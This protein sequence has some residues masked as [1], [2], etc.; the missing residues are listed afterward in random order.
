MVGSITFTKK[1]GDYVRK[2]DEVHTSINKRPCTFPSVQCYCLI[3]Q[4]NSFHLHLLNCSL[5]I[6]HLEE[7]LSSVCLKRSVLG[8]LS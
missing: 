1:K 4:R 6:S 3:F 5:D 7:V 2:G 8:Y